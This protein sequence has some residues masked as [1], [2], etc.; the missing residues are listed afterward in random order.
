MEESNNLSVLFKE[1]TSVCY[2]GERLWF[3]HSYV[4][5]ETLTFLCLDSR[6]ELSEMILEL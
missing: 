4:V 5:S 1:L 6:L 2:G 3:E